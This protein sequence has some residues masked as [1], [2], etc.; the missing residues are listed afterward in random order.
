MQ[1]CHDC[2]CLSCF[3]FVSVQRDQTKTCNICMYIFVYCNTSVNVILRS[4]GLSKQIQTICV[5][6]VFCTLM[7]MFQEIMPSF[8]NLLYVRVGACMFRRRCNDAHTE[9]ICCVHVHFTQ[10]SN[11]QCVCIII[12]VYRERVCLYIIVIVCYIS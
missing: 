3:C 8:D 11:L 2:I 4:N 10:Y 6:C 7:S 5:F 1:L 9:Q 12:Y